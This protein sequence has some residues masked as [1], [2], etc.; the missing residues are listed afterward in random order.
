MRDALLLFTMINNTT[1]AYVF[2]LGPKIWDMLPDY[3]EDI[4]NLNIFK[5]KVTKWKP[6][7]CP[8]ML[9]KIYINNMGF[10]RERKRSLEYSSSIF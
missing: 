6:E 3:R 8:C 1:K 9:C 4:D 7:N 2:F 10:V 5:N